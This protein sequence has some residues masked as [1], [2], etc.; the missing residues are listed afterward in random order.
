MQTVT[1]PVNVDA[2]VIS[3]VRPAKPKPTGGSCGVEVAV[4]VVVPA[5]VTFAKVMLTFA[6][7]IETFAPTDVFADTLASLKKPPRNGKRLL[8]LPP[9]SC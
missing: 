4:T 6:S 7:E 8:K 2:V 1:G 3:N 9:A 5:E